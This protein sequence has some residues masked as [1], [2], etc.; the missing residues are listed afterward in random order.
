MADVRALGAL[1][2]DVLAT[3]SEI[4]LAHDVTGWI[5]N[6]KGTNVKFI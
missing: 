1:S 6:S 3:V 5:A 4:I 2:A